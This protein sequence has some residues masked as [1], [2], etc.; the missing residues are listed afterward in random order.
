MS[1][2]NLSMTD[3][4]TALLST[5][6][7]NYKPRLEDNIFRQL[8]LLYWLN[9]KG[10]KRTLD[11]GLY[12]H[13]PLL[14]GE[15]TTVMSFKGYDLLDVTPQ[16]GIT[17]SVYHWKNASVSISISREEE[18]K[19]SGAHRLIGLLEAKTMQA[20]KSLQW[21]LNDLL[22]GVYSSHEKTFAGS[23]INTRD[24]VG[25]IRIDSADGTGDGFTS[26]DHM[27]RSGWGLADNTATT[28]TSHVVGGISTT[29]KFSGT[30]GANY[31]D[32]SNGDNVE[33]TVDTDN[34][35]NPWWLN[36]SNPGF[37]RLQRGADGGRILNTVPITE[38]DNACSFGTDNANVVAAMRSMY[39]RLSDG[40]D[41]PDL[42]L[43]GQGMY[44]AYEGALSPLER[45]TDTKLGDAGFQNLK[46]KGATMVFDHGI[47]S[48][49]PAIP[50]AAAPAQPM[51]FLNSDYLEWTVDS[52]SDFMP[53][54]FYRPHKQAARVAQILLMAQLCTSNR[55]K[56]GVISFSTAGIYTPA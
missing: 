40:S 23:D 52:Q 43:T 7:R 20:E 42:I 36:Y 31:V 32:W 55:S 24:S 26:L 41:T 10:R 51:Y 4:Y 8:P 48:G 50:T 29:T 33:L 2:A 28:A 11:G 17:H 13:V 53:T 15:N 54:P 56:H 16:E 39:N 6:L 1:V 47:S 37:S 18:R 30:V 35:V 38:L 25:G 44:E 14:Y 34:F 45:F 46:F 27:V 9:D 22:H 21:W 3:E 19:N 5:T 12:I 49:L